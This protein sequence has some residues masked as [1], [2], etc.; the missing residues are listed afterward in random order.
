MA[1]ARRG[2]QLPTQAVI[3]P[4]SI[5]EAPDAITAYE[6]GGRKCQEWQQ[7]L[8]AN[9]L[10]K[11]DDGL[12]IHLKFGYE[13][14]RQ[15][16]KGEVLLIRERYGIERGERILHTAHKTSTS[17]SA[18]MKLKKNLD[19]SGYVELGRKKKD[20]VIPEKCYKAT[21]QYGLEE[22]RIGADEDGGRI[23][24]RTRTE[25]GGIGESFDTLV[26]DEAQEYTA[27]QESALQY[28]IAASP[29]PQTILTGTPPTPQSKGDVYVAYRK[30]CLSGESDGC[31]WAEWSVYDK[32]S[33]PLDVD[34]WYQTNPSL[35]KLLS[36]RTVRSE[37]KPDTKLDFI[38]QRLGYWHT[39]ELK[40]EITEAQWLA[41]KADSLPVLKGK[42]HVGVRFG[43]N[44]ANT[45]L[46]IACKTGDGKIFVETIDC[47]PQA[48]GMDWIMRFLRGA[49]I[50]SIVIDGKG[51]SE[52]LKQLIDAS[53]IKAKVFQVS[54]AE[55]VVAYSGFRQSIDEQ[56][57][58]HMAQP[59]V[60]QAVSNCERRMIGSNGGFGFRSM[61]DNVD[62]TIVESIAL[63]RWACAN[64]KER[65]KQ[66]IGY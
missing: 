62:V 63:A 9:I 18:Y 35:G 55:A 65:R 58:C 36:E 17:H 19:D 54:T 25:S 66:K 57:I 60:T 30:D 37:Y 40:S 2:S 44:G 13:V 21:K 38:I 12:W 42:L 24:F 11:D 48:N 51:K 22:I 47:Q 29:N 34:L 43:A 3:L 61:H 15:N 53:R 49:D 45:S 64:A 10:A 56:T 20:R 50:Q 6:E 31:G 16:G 41:L 46:S 39:Y 4:Y 28:T 32:P 7:S 26:I 52:L 8:L 59:S 14:P 33:D 5:T 1:T 23:V 27:A